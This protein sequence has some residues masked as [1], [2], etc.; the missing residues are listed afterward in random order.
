M[1]LAM[2][3]TLYYLAAHLPLKSRLLPSRHGPAFAALAVGEA[4]YV[5]ALLNCADGFLYVA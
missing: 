5:G 2:P 1:P 4:L 3:L